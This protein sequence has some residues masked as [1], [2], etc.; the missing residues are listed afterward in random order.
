M[1][2]QVLAQYITRLIPKGWNVHLL[3]C[4]FMA[5]RLGFMVATLVAA[6]M[7]GK[8]RMG[9]GSTRPQPP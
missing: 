8:V 3:A 4:K 2:L 5:I 9:R 6:V 7:V 1:K